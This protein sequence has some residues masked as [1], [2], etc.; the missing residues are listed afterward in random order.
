MSRDQHSDRRRVRQ[1][2]TVILQLAA[3]SDSWET[4]DSDLE[5]LNSVASSRAVRTLI[6]RPG[7]PL[8]ER[9]DTLEGLVRN[10]L[11]SEGLALSRVLLEDGVFDLFPTVRAQYLRRSSQDGPVDR[12]TISGAVPLTDGETR[13]LLE[14]LR[15]PDR[16]L[17]VEFEENPAILG[18]LVIRQGDWRRDLSV[19]A[20]LDALEMAIR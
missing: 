10:L 7:L 13:R 9:L 16:K 20:R 4:W 1:Y 8:Q 15:Q 19:S 2:V 17:L 14:S 11:S 5:I 18:G 6:M 3:E 12:V